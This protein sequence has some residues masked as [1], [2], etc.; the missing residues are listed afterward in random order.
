MISSH[1][2]T[3][4]DEDHYGHKGAKDRILEFLTVGKL[5]GTVKGRIICL[6]GPPGVGKIDLPHAQSTVLPVF[7]GW[8]DGCSINKGPQTHKIIQTLRESARRIL[9]CSSTKLT[10]SAGVTTV[11]P[12]ARCWRRLLQSKT[13]ASWTI[14]N[15]LNTVPAPLLGHM[16]VLEVSGYV[17]GER[18]VITNKGG[19]LE[20]SAIDVPIKYYRREWGLELELIRYTERQGLEK[21]PSPNIKAVESQEL[22]SHETPAST[23]APDEPNAPLPTILAEISTEQT[24]ATTQKWNPMSIPESVHACI[25]PETPKDY[26]GPPVYK[27]DRMHFSPP[28]PGV[29]VGLACPPKP[30]SVACP[31]CLVSAWS[32]KRGL[33]LMGKFGEVIRENAQ[34]GLSWVKGHTLELGITSSSSE[35]L[36]DDRDIYIHAPEGSLGKEGLSAGAATLDAFVS[37]FTEALI[38]RSQAHRADTKAMI[39][40]IANRADIEGNVPERLKMG[41]LFI[42][43][44]HAREVLLEVFRGEPITEHSTSEKS[45]SHDATRVM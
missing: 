14:T 34:I 11:I 44:E 23:I 43:V 16:E 26:V 35:Q 20:P 3:V 10:K 15:N 13:I 36:L 37:L 38:H 18:V 22:A 45:T 33:Q 2:Q 1:T 5:H 27:K 41:I 30:W 32:G 42:Y 21:K 9:W 12:R 8:F 7:S 39:A 40:P 24:V 17:S 19:V 29:S 4:L 31:I 6:V 25:T 28:S